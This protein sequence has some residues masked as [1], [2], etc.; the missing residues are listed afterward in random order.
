MQSEQVVREFVEK[1]QWLQ[2]VEYGDFKRKVNLYIN[3]LMEQ[4]KNTS[5]EVKELAEQIRHKVV[6]DPTEPDV[7]RARE[8]VVTTGQKMLRYFH[9]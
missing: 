5:P 2:E 3:R 4:L 8:F 9:N 7:E 1:V 6:F